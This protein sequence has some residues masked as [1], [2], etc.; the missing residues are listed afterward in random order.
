MWQV[1]FPPLGNFFGSHNA[2]TITPE[3]KGIEK[4]HCVANVTCTVYEFIGHLGCPEH[5]LHLFSVTYTM[6]EFIGHL[7]CP[8]HELHVKLR[9]LFY[10]P[11]DD[12]S[13]PPA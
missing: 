7:V 11:M 13:I 4:A 6:Y 2:R 12:L 1:L 9:V 3:D 8:E 5:E 10:E